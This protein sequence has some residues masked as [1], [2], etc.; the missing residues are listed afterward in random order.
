MI[1]RSGG[2]ASFCC[3]QNVS[4][5]WLIA[6]TLSVRPHPPLSTPT[7]SSH[8]LQDIDYSAYMAAL[9]DELQRITKSLH[10]LTRSNAELQEE[11]RHSELKDPDFKLAIEDNIVTIAK[12]R[13]RAESLVEEIARLEA[14]AAS[15]A[16]PCM[17]DLHPPQ[18][19]LPSASLHHASSADTATGGPGSLTPED[20]VMV[21]LP[22]SPNGSSR[23]T[24]AHVAQEGL[25]DKGVWL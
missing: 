16:A 25:G 8:D 6:L 12:F 17:E 19:E 2:A 13:A 5:L 1:A 9:K 20:A 15:A 4:H 18:P 10:H 3:R 21:D 22:S 11:M 24:G 7:G 23:D 14:G